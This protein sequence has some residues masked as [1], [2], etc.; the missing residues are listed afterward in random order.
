MLN[1][2]PRI[3]TA[4]TIPENLSF[5]QGFRDDL[6]AQTVSPHTR[7]AYLSDLIQ[8]NECVKSYLPSWTHDD[9][10][11]VLLELTKQG[12]SPRSIARSLSAL[13]AFYKFLPIFVGPKTRREGH[14][15]SIRAFLPTCRQRYGKFLGFWIK[16]G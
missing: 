8:C 7:N 5:L 14:R 2:K 10:S 11:D 13:R 12:K 1:K 9:I 15:T 4:V 3:R 16:L 6:I